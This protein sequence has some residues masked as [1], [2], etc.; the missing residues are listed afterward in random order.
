MLLLAVPFHRRIPEYGSKSDGGP[1]ST[2][3]G[4]HFPF[5]SLNPGDI[6][7]TRDTSVGSLSSDIDITNVS[8][9]NVGFLAILL[10]FSSLPMV[11]GC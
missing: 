10:L 7:D 2:F 5:L 4:K 8:R 6:R 11:S 1:H 9:K 3:P